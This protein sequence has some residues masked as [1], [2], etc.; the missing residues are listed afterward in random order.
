MGTEQA[1]SDRTG[2]RT[3]VEFDARGR[4]SL[5]K[6]GVAPG[7]YVAT[8]G[9]DGSVLLE[10]AHVT[11]ELEERFRANRALVERVTND[12]ADLSSAKPAR[13]RARTRAKA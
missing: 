10:P 3:I 8:T 1:E 5:G 11:T 9:A 7:L 2:H 12:L 6:L 4:V 13:R